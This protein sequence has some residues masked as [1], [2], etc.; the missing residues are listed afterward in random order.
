MTTEDETKPEQQMLRM[1]EYQCN[2]V[3]LAQKV[4]NGLMAEAQ[5]LVNKGNAKANEARDE[6]RKA[7]EGAFTGAGR[8][9]PTAEVRI[10]ND[11]RGRPAVLVW[12]EP[13]KAE[14]KDE[15]SAEE[16]EQEKPKTNGKAPLPEAIKR[17]LPI[18]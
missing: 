3:A 8:P 12:S 9:V 13:Q 14:E 5:D 15:E 18:K 17:K 10:V 6:L 16:H 2:Y 1:T 7:V 11:E 4:H